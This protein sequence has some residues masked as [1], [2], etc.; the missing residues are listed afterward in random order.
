MN[1]NHEFLAGVLRQAARALV[2]YAS[3]GLLEKHPEAKKGFEPDPFVGWQNWFDHPSGST[4]QSRWSEG[5]RQK[6]PS[7]AI[8][9]HQER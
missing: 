8:L 7:L 2:G 5:R 3:R 6:T 9:Y 1:A 4:Q